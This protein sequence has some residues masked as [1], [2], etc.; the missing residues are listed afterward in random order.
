MSTPKQRRNALIRETGD[1]TVTQRAWAELKRRYGGCCA[2]CGRKTVLLEKD[3]IIP[4]SKGGLHT[5]SNIVPACG[6]CNNRKHDRTPQ[7]AGMVLRELA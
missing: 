1:W 7:E 3:H 6:P 2:Y 5:I 4:L